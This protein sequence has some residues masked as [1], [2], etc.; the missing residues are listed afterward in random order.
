MQVQDWENAG[1]GE[2]LCGEGVC[3]YRYRKIL[4]GESYQ[5]KDDGGPG[6]YGTGQEAGP[7]IPGP[8]KL[9]AAVIGSE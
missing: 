3:A 4:C 7:S 6:A 8:P 1:R 9:M 5:Q 2:L